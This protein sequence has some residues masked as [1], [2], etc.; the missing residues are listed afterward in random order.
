MN[1]WYDD[2]EYLVFWVGIVDYG[3]TKDLRYIT[4]NTRLNPNEGNQLFSLDKDNIC[5]AVSVRYY[6]SLMLN[7]NEFSCSYEMFGLCELQVN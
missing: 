1:R 5:V 2:I 4:H 6:K 7:A 3:A